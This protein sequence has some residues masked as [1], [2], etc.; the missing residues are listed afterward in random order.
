MYKC[1]QTSGHN[2]PAGKKH[3]LYPFLAVSCTK[4]IKF[5]ARIV[6][7]V[8]AIRLELH[9]DILTVLEIPHPLKLIDL[10]SK[11]H[12]CARV[13]KFGSVHGYERAWL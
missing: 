10:W 13:D 9:D 1:H 12:V 7:L 6:Q 5:Q 8:R 3:L 11:W 4:V 2:H